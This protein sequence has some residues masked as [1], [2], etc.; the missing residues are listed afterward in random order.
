VARKANGI[1]CPNLALY[2]DLS[3]R[4]L[5]LTCGENPSDL[6]LEGFLLQSG[7]VALIMQLIFWNNRVLKAAMSAEYGDSGGP[8]VDL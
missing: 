3:V 2:D 4:V 5:T 1:G 6:R 7:A 8:M